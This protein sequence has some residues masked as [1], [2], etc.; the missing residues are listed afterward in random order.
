VLECG[1]E[2]VGEREG[3]GVRE[4]EGEDCGCAL[5]GIWYGV[6]GMSR[7]WNVRGGGMREGERKRE[8]TFVRVRVEERLNRR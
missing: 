1:E 4:K 6:G 3:F 7:C 8:R 5:G 2:G